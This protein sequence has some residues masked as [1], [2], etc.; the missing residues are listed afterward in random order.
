MVQAALEMRPRP[1]SLG[2][3]GPL[4]AAALVILTGSVVSGHGTRIAAPVA[5]LVVLGAVVA[6]RLRSW[7]ALISSIVLI[8]L[9]IPMKRYMLPASLPIRL[10]PYRFVVAVVVVV[11][12][13]SALIDPRVRLRRTRVIDLPLL[14]FTLAVA[15]SEMANHARVSTVG[16]DVLKALL[17]FASFIA[18]L[19]LVVSLLRSL[20]DIEFVVRM[21]VA[22]GA[23]V[24]F[25]ALIESDRLQRLRPSVAGA[26]DPTSYG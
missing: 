13:T 20:D 5:A 18:V 4:L 11:W 16:S 22:G 26:A 23:V 19:F 24:A 9:F 21:L 25:F 10:E 15:G 8:I 14:A 6:P 3:S 2:F 7:R 1:P 12:L 17:F